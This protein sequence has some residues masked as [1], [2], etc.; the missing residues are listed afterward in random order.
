[1]AKTG[2]NSSTATEGQSIGSKN[3]AS[4]TTA[5]KVQNKSYE[6][7][8]QIDGIHPWQSSVDNGAVLYPVRELPNGKVI[9]FNFKLAREMGLI[10]KDH[11]DHLNK[12]LE[13]KILKTFAIQIINEYD[14]INNR[15][16]DPATIK[17]NK[18]MATRY[19]QLQHPN[20]QGR[21]S[22]DGRSIWNGMIKFRGKSWDI[23]SRGTGVTCL[24]PGAVEAGKPLKSG[25]ETFGYGCGMAELDE[26]VAT[27]IFS[28]IL[29]AQGIG[30]ERM[31]AIVE[32]GQGLG[33]GVRASPNLIRPA[34]IFRF[35]K[36]NDYANC[37]K[38]ADYL[39]ERQN[40]NRE[41]NIPTKSP[42][43]YQLMVEA[44]NKSFAKFAARLDMD[45]IFA[46]LDWDGDNVLANAGIIDYGSI[47]QFG[48]RHDAYRYEDVDRYSTN[49]NEQ[50]AKSRLLV[51]VFQQLADFLDTKT[52]KVISEYTN[53]EISKKFNEEF[54]LQ[55]LRCLLYRVGFRNH[56]IESLMKNQIQAVREFYSEY[57]FFER[58]K[59]HSSEKKTEDGVNRPAIFSLKDG[60]REMSAFYRDHG[61]KLMPAGQLFSIL[62]ASTAGAR[63]SKM[64]D[65]QAVRLESLQSKYLKLIELS[66][67]RR[68]FHR[69]IK[70]IAA[71]SAVINRRDRITGNSITLITDMILDARKKKLSQKDFQKVI[72]S[73]VEAQVL[74]PGLGYDDP[75]KSLVGLRDNTRRV[76]KSLF[77]VAKECADDI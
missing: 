46:W 6:K 49:L 65:T 76:L 59:T 61:Q 15:K 66:L 21:T 45:Y 35:L 10:S 22:G 16:F 69:M 4:T 43:R 58:V 18:F 26:L 74:V 52:K 28:E 36:Q 37:K 2:S 3:Q 31:L 39:I 44:L 41:W 53:H 77:Q 30:T 29:H 54:E 25:D 75:N 60:L 14:Q 57:T 24:A 55:R 73:F 50:K 48:V 33:V 17:P 64:S 13:K 12:D 20:K 7:F 11:P 27:A 8:D 19:L 70:E 32:M 9:Y 40:S 23:S 47:R 62:L 67:G 56:D 5:D 1:V 72:E 42:K 51:Q 71:R 38:A 34:H 63:D 68:S